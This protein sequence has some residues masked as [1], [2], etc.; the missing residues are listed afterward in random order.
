MDSRERTFLAL[1]H[2][3]PDRVPVDLWMSRGFRA[4]LEAQLNTTAAAF[5]DQHD[6][7]W[8]YVEGPRY[9]GPPLRRWDDG[10]D[11]DIWGVRRRPAVVQLAGGGREHYM[12]VAASP[13]AAAASVEQVDAYGHWPSPDWY[14]YTGVAAM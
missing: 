9:V 6:V 4:R 2:Q 11:E 10:S 3:E 7:D 1:D 5:L 8:R 12:E 14:E 13:L